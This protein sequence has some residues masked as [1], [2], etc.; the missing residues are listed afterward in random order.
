MKVLVEIQFNKRLLSVF[1][2]S[3]G[4]FGLIVS[5]AGSC[6]QKI[7]WVE[8]REGERLVERWQHNGDS[9]KNGI[10]ESFYENGNIFERAEYRNDVLNGEKKFYF[11]NGQVQSIEQHQMGN[12]HG[13]FKS[14]DSTGQVMQIALYE[15]NQTVG[16]LLNYYRNGQLKE[17]V[18]F[19]NGTENGPFVEYFENG[20][21]KA[22]GN[23]KDGDQEHGILKLYDSTGVL[24]RKMNC[25]MGICRTF[26]K[27]DSLS[28]E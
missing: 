27:A 21:L 9:I 12:Y 16:D 15:D 19:E 1:Y 23:Y 17:K 8:I 22:E 11:E 25:E 10:Y 26:W 5:M 6:N 18:H 20:Q 13:T 24:I 7:Q 3:F 14:F 2:F 28:N 4:V